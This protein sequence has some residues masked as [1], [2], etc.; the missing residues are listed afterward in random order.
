MY[1]NMHGEVVEQ[2]LNFVKQQHK[3]Y[4]NELS[5]KKYMGVFGVKQQHKMYWNTHAIALMY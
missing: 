1:W 4:W 2:I 3:M 5:A